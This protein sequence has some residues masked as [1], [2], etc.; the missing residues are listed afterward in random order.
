MPTEIFRQ[1]LKHQGDMCR[2]KSKSVSDS[3]PAPYLAFDRNHAIEQ[4]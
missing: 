2:M 4:C 3:I 1:S